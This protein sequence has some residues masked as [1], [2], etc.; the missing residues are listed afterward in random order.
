M[1]DGFDFVT[2]ANIARI[3]ADLVDAVLNR[4]QRQTIVEMN[5]RDKR[6]RD[7]LLDLLDRFRGFF[8]VHRDAH[9]LA[10]RFFQPVNLGYSRLNVRRLRGAH[11]LNDDVIASANRNVAYLYRSCLMSQIHIILSHAG[12]GRKSAD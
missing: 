11:A 4:L 5:I 7:L 3:D 6:Y 2:A 1:D 12:N 8:I 9:D 10:S